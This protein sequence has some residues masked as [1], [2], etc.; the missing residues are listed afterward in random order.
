M[1]KQKAGWKKMLK[2][3]MAGTI[4]IAPVLIGISAAQAAPRSYSRTTVYRSETVYLTITGRVTSVESNSR[5]NIEVGNTEYNV[6]LS[7][8]APRRLDKGDT[9][10][11]YGRRYGN[12]DIRN[13]SVAIIINTPGN[14]STQWGDFRT[15]TGRVTSVESN[16]RFNI[17]VGNTDYNV[18]LSSS[19]PR[20]LD[21]GDIVQVYG[22][23]YGNNDI[24]NANVRI[25][26]NTPGN[27]STQ[28][29]DFRTFTGRVTSVESNTRFN[30]QVDGTEYNVYLSS[31]AP[32][33]LDRNDTVRVYGR[34]YGNNDIRNANVSIIN[35]TPG[36]GSGQ[37]GD[38]ATFTGVAG[39]VQ[40]QRFRL[41]VGGITYDVYAS[42]RLPADL[43]QGDRVRVYGR[44]YGENDI[45]NATVVVVRNR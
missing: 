35:N 21:N 42:T 6:Y 31:S 16:S 39:T 27:G 44:R 8:S 33:R 24:R 20:R 29:G 38:F 37:W 34:R 4:A 3:S 13:A 18:Y 36:N 22:R 7:T 40:A 26:R 11:V 30:I 45:R 10:R 2:V 19:A 25:I 12:N 5:F 17:E 32:R 9:V 28:W 15:F 41:E 1:K 43:N 23:R 14:G